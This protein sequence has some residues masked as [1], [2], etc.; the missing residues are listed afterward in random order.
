MRHYVYGLIDPRNCGVFYVGKGTAARRFHHFK[1]APMDARK[2]PDKVGVFDNIKAAGLRPQ[3]IVLSW[4]DTQEKAYDAE[5]DMIELIGLDN[6]TNKNAGGAGGV[7]KSANVSKEKTQR[8]SEKQEK[9]AQSVASGMT[10][11]DAYKE[12]Y[13]AEKS[14]NKSCNERSS[15]LMADVKI[16]SRVDE[17]KAPVIQKLRDVSL[18]TKEGQLKRFDEMI[19]LAITTDQVG[20]AINALKE[21]TK[22]MDLYP[23]QKNVNTNTNVD[24]TDRINA[25]RDRVAKLKLVNEND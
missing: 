17:L 11:S 9:F 3:A 15:A 12:S 8:L 1:S 10:Y 21:Q 5:K 22:I 7:L 25:G 16:S 18:I 6:L 19:D 2:N 23:A 20:A 14:T 4:H 24:L 13:N